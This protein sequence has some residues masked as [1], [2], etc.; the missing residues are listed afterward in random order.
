MSKTS[1]VIYKVACEFVEWVILGDIQTLL[2][3]TGARAYGLIFLPFMWC[4]AYLIV[5]RA[6]RGYLNSIIRIVI[7]IYQD[8]LYGFNILVTNYTF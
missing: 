4:S 1:D 5:Y 2:C 6:T 8:K 3:D 7:L